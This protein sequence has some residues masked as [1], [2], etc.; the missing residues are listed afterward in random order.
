MDSST[1]YS[2]LICSSCQQYL[3]EF[4][5]L[6][7][8]WIFRQIELRKFVDN[9]TSNSYKEVDIKEEIEVIDDDDSLGFDNDFQAIS[10]E[11]DDDD[12][13]I[14]DELKNE[15]VS[16][17]TWESEA[18]KFEFPKRNRKKVYR[19]HKCRHCDSSFSKAQTLENHQFYQHKE[20]L[21]KEEIERIRKNDR[22]NRMR[23]CPQCG[24]S[25]EQLKQHI[26]HVHL[27]I[28]RFF[29]DG[30]DYA[31]FKKFNIRSHVLRHAQLEKKFT[32]EFCGKKLSRKSSFNTHMRDFHYNVKKNIKFTCHCGSEF[33]SHAKLYKHKKWKHTNSKVPCPSCG[34]EITKEGLSEHTR[35]D[36]EDKIVDYTCSDCNKKFPNKRCLTHHRLIHQ[37]RSFICDFPECHR[38]F[39]SLVQLQSH[40]KWHSSTKSLKCPYQGCDKTYSKQQGLKIHVATKHENY[41]KS[42][43]V[44]NC[45]YSSGIFQDMRGHVK[46]HK[47]FRSDVLDEYI[48][49]VRKLNLY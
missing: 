49:A 9:S 48:L 30:C 39:L 16:R 28:K 8:D 26:R 1:S 15:D 45:T 17:R 36:P 18:D 21:T 11:N 43:P 13:K 42:C 34:K 35:V 10:D 22:L 4:T 19:E 20:T 3:N 23:I 12:E 32:C 29:C 25:T 7:N 31:T 2:K 46:R 41:R 47:E 27:Q 24:I 38:A 6:K 5:I 37:E 40:V 14:K 33:S 44:P